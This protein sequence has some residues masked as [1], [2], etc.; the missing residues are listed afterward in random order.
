MAIVK[1]T[2]IY[3]V[4]PQDKKDEAVEILENIGSIHIVNL[5]SEIKEPPGD[6][7]HE[8]AKTKR[9]VEHLKSLRIEV[10]K[11]PELS[12]DGDIT[13]IYSS[14]DKL[15][16][17]RNGFEQRINVIDKDLRILEPW[18]DFELEDIDKLKARNLNIDFYSLSK[19]ELKEDLELEE[20]LKSST[21]YEWKKLK[22]V[23]SEGLV[24]ISKPGFSE[25]NYDKVNLPKKSISENLKEKYRIETSLESIKDEL[26]KL[27]SFLGLFE[28]YYEKIHSDLEKTKVTN[29][30][31]DHGPVFAISGY[32][33]SK[34]EKTIE[35]KFKGYPIG[36]IFEKPTIEDDVPIQ[37]NNG[38]LVRYFEP[39]IKMFNL[40]NYHEPDTTILVAPFMFVFFGFCM[41]DAAYGLLLLGFATW[42]ASKLKKNEST[43]VFM[44]LLQL[45]GLSTAVIG[46]L[47]GSFMGISL[48]SAPWLK[49][50]HNIFYLSYLSKDP[51]NFFSFAIKLGFLQLFVG[52][53]IKM[54]IA[55]WKKDFQA[56]LAAVGLF[57]FGIMLYIGFF[58]FGKIPSESWYWY[59]MLACLT[60]I[61]LFGGP[62]SNPLIRVGK[63]FWSIYDGAIGFV[64]DVIS[65]ARIFGLGLSSGI[66][67]GVVND[68]GMSLL[69]IKPGGVPVG[70]VIV[71]FFLIF[72]HTFNFAMAIIGSLVHSAR[73]NFLEYYGKFFDGGGKPYKPFGKIEK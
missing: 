60:P 53:L 50:F 39:L 4:G 23:K 10:E 42:G 55:T 8:V 37:F 3:L 14:Y 73:L 5:A 65:Y 70:W 16:S 29:G 58:K 17:D 57:G 13:E 62:H 15:L 51:K 64:G 44:R 31:L 67:A 18:G 34:L 24:V 35:S 19:K 36:L 45:L 63:G 69:S 71:P 41:A 49:G 6:L 56:V 25:I 47:M 22:G 59:A 7:T 68:L 9:V 52:V 11:A 32:A 46:F 1:M 27:S 33:P 20:L 38:F 26:L 2:K 61:L 28:E 66:I 54:F 40:P 12:D 30:L 48:F 21:W 43:L 72:G